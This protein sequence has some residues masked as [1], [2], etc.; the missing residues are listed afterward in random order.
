MARRCFRLA[1]VAGIST[2]DWGAECESLPG[3][4]EWDG[5]S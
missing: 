5:M 3:A 4:V 2:E 1:C